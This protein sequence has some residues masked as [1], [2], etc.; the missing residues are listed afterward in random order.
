MG[1][2]LNE[3]SCR[4]SDRQA[5]FPVRLCKHGAQK[6]PPTSPA[7]SPLSA[8][9]SGKMPVIWGFFCGWGYVP[10]AAHQGSAWPILLAPH[11]YLETKQVAWRVEGC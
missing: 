1:I 3:V 9:I 2:E 10:G 11:L 5:V 7:P 6:G 8:L 4:C